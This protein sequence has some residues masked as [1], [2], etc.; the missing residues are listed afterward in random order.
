MNMNMDTK[1]KELIDIDAT[2]IYFYH[3]DPLLEFVIAAIPC[4]LFIVAFIIRYL[5]IKDLG[6]PKRLKFGYL[7]IFK[8]V[9]TMGIMLVRFL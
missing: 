8:L 2:M 1:P 7:L 3:G 9:L 4:Y 6:F 5:A